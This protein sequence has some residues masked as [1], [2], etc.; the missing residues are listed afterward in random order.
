MANNTIW[1][2]K[3][4]YWLLTLSFRKDFKDISPDEFH[5]ASPDS[6]DILIVWDISKFKYSR[7]FKSVHTI[8]V[9]RQQDVIVNCI[10]NHVPQSIFI[11][12][13]LSSTAWTHNVTPA[14]Y[15]LITTISLH[16]Y[17]HDMNSY[18]MFTLSSTLQKSDFTP[19]MNCVTSLF[20]LFILIISY[21]Q[22]DLI[23]SQ[24]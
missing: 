20:Q 11:C 12:S 1:R 13:T 23:I 24:L 18:H 16:L 14:M 4:I 22:S 3:I 7:F 10:S 2:F 6:H 8:L 15:V 9:Y 17:P 5:W 19:V 21:S